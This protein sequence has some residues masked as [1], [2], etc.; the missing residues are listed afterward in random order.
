MATNKV[1]GNKREQHLFLSQIAEEMGRYG[2][3]DAKCPVCD[4]SFL[5]ERKGSSYVLRCETEG[6]LKFTSRGI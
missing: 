4:G 6:C 2:H 5:L 1:L 3:S